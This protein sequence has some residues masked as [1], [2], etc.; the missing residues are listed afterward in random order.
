MTNG[1]SKFCFPAAM[2]LEFSLGLAISLVGI[3]LSVVSG[4]SQLSHMGRFAKI[5]KLA[6]L[7][8]AA[9]VFVSVIFALYIA[10]TG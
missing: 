10:H 9:L 8:S 7:V 3:G 2:A 1:L 5:T 6:T 4:L